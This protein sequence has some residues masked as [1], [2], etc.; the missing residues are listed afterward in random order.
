M[1]PFGREGEDLEKLLARC[2]KRDQRAWAQLVER[3]QSLV[4]S[5]PRRMG[6]SADDCEDVFQSTFSA[7]YQALDRIESGQA[8][9]K[10][11]AVTATRTALRLKRASG[12]TTQFNEAVTLDEL[13]AEEERSAEQQ[14]VKSQQGEL[15]RAGIAGLPDKC[16]QLLTL[17]YFDDEK[18]YQDISEA[19]GMPMGAIGP[20]RARCLDRLRRVLE[21]HGFGPE[22]ITDAAPTKNVR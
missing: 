2:R 1:N 22:D 17:L 9:P 19:M 21:S 10:W 8:M 15:V 7:F 12:Q 18:S 16:R 20:N 6:L 14:A 4:Y 5:I 11:F 3:F 13:V